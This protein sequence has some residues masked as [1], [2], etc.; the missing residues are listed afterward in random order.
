MLKAYDKVPL[1]KAMN[2]SV[3]AYS[4]NVWTSVKVDQV[5]G[6]PQHEVFKS[7]LCLPSR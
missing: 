5:L 3:V 7:F 1:S 2:C 6:F 4:V